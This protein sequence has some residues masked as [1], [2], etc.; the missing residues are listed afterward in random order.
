MEFGLC[1]DCGLGFDL[2]LTHFLLLLVTAL[3]YAVL[4]SQFDLSPPQFTFIPPEMRRFPQP[5]LNNIVA[6]LQP[7]AENCAYC[8][9]AAL[10]SAV[11][12]RSCG[13]PH[14]RDCFRLHG[15]CSV[16][17]CGGKSMRSVA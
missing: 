8:K 1:A 3:P 2:L 10:Y 15:G 13:T 7:A 14:H 16:Y 5:M 4:R 6:S 12:C 17:G 11:R 9:A